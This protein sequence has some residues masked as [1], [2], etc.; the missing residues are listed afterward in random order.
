MRHSDC[1]RLAKQLLPSLSGLTTDKR[2]LLFFTPIGDILRGFAFES[3]AYAREEFYFWWFFMPIGRPIEYLTLG[4]GGRLSP[5]IGYTDWRTHMEDLPNKLLSALRPKALPLLQSTITY[6]DTINAIHELRGEQ[7]GTDTNILDDL[8]CLQILDG[9]FEAARQTLDALISHE[10]GDDRRQWI[11]DIVE[12]AKGL[13]EKLINDPQF[14]ID[15]VKEWQKHT[16][17][18]LKLEMWRQTEPKM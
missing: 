12:R 15:Q 2:D 13:K 10:H 16:F 1:Y 7:A 3:T 18:A 6:Q 9:Q 17:K 8:S 5:P 11:L 14:A 4:Y